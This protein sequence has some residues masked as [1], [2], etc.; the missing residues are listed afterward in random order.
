MLPVWL[1]PIAG[2]M[3]PFLLV[4]VSTGV[5][6]AGQIHC[7]QRVTFLN[8]FFKRNFIDLIEELQQQFIDSSC[9]VVFCS[10][11]NLERV[12]KSVRAAPCVE[13]ARIFFK[14][15]EKILK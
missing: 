6:S 11:E 10:P 13:V 5:P 2:N 15:F 12:Q 3:C 1:C 4:L 7:S 14:K 9:S 8:V